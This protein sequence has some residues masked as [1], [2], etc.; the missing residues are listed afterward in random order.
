MQ[1]DKKLPKIKR[2]L[3]ARIG[4]IIAIVLL[5]LITL[6]VLVL[7]LIQTGP[8]Q[9]FGRKKI[10]SFLEKKLDTKV[11]IN[12]LSIDFPKMLVLEGV[13]IEDKQ[14]DTLLSGNQLKVDIDMFKLLESEIQINQIK[15]NGITAKVKRQLPDTTFNFQFIIDAFVTAPTTKSTDTSSLKISIEKIV[16]DKTRLVYTDV[17]TGNDIDIYLNHFDTHISKFDLNHIDFVVPD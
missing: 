15:L 10:V 7:L 3:L 2:N 16:V 1:T 9:N 11:A 8:V 6:I 14:K 4:R 5:S 17:V 13:Y 12:R